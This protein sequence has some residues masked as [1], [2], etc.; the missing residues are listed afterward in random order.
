MMSLPAGIADEKKIYSM[1]HGKPNIFT[2][3][4]NTPP[5]N[6]YIDREKSAKRSRGEFGRLLWGR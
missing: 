5:A 4:K 1:T 2:P 6:P 3:I